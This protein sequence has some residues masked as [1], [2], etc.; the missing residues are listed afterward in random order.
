MGQVEYGS[1]LSKKWFGEANDTNVPN[2]STYHYRLSHLSL[3]VDTG[4]TVVRP[5]F[6]TSFLVS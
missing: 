2:Y 1:H 5:I 4:K 3:S 6:Q